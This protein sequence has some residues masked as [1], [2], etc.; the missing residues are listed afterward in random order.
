MGRDPD[1]DEGY[2]G[3]K[4]EV[5]AIVEGSTLDLSF[6][7]LSAP[8]KVVYRSNDR[9]S[10]D[11]TAVV[12][13]V[14][15]DAGAAIITLDSTSRIMSV[16]AARAGHLLLQGAAPS[17]STS[18]SCNLRI[19]VVRAIPS[20]SI[21]LTEL[22]GLLEETYTTHRP[23]Y[24]SAQCFQGNRNGSGSYERQSE[25]EEFVLAQTWSAVLDTMPIP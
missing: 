24:R 11:P 2:S 16:K 13:D 4:E 12:V 19:I 22:T 3:E 21:D 17:T 18:L 9:A 25:E 14:F 8:L 20:P 5:V 7:T 10:S 6:C 23:V 15:D 1:H